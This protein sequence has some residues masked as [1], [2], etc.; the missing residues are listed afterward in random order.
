MKQHGHLQIQTTFGMASE[1][2]KFSY[3][4]IVFTLI[5]DLGAKMYKHIE[6]V[7]AKIH[8]FIN[9]HSVIS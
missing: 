4:T 1:K 3:S 8:A 5:S 7:E 2:I 9:L 6:N